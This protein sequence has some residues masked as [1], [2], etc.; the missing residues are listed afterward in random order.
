[1]DIYLT[2]Q[3]HLKLC[4]LFDLE[5]QSMEFEPIYYD[6][7][8]EPEPWNKGMKFEFVPK[9]KDHRESMKKA[10]IKRKQEGK[11]IQ[12]KTYVAS[13]KKRRENCKKH[14]FIHDSGIIE[15]NLTVIELSQK[16]P[17][18]KLQ[19]SNLRKAIGCG[20]KGYI[21]S[22]GWRILTGEPEYIKPRKIDKRTMRKLMIKGE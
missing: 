17:E 4:E 12:E 15:H 14:N 10:W 13:L 16:Y 5:Y 2:Q 19:P 7:R 20:V 18:Q 9:S 3:T 21:K 6:G 11:I 1:M 8:V 22:K